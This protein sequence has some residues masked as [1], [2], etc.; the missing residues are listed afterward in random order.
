VKG[1]AL[2]TVIKQFAAQ[3]RLLAFNQ[4]LIKHHF[5]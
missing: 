1:G 5:H 4:P 2:G 3:E